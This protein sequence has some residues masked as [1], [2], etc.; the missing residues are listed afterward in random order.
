MLKPF[1]FII[2]T[3]ILEVDADG[4]PVDE[5]V[6][7]QPAVLYGVPAVRDFLDKLEAELQAQEAE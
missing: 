5:K 7:E 3:V 1:K 2:Q 6:S 4:N